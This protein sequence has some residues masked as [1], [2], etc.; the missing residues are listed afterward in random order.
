MR[1]YLVG[2]RNA[3]GEYVARLYVLPGVNQN[4]EMWRNV[5]LVV[6]HVHIIA[7]VRSGGHTV[8]N[9][10]AISECRFVKETLRNFDHL[11]HASETLELLR[12]TLQY[13][14]AVFSVERELSQ[15]L[16]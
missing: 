1:D 12:R 7:S 11:A 9:T 2:L 8:N 13:A 5:V 3:F 16:R 10:G 6:A 14:H 4:V 15:R